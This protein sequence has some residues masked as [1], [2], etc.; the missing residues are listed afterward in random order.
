MKAINWTAKAEHFETLAA[1]AAF[2]AAVSI[3][4]SDAEAWNDRAA[5]YDAA[6]ADYRNAAR[7]AA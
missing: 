4:A 2:N 3:S 1:R 7:K 5:R 6:A